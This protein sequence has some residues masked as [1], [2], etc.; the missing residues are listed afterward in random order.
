MIYYFLRSYLIEKIICSLYNSGHVIIQIKFEHVIRSVFFL[1][2][3]ILSSNSKI[4]YFEKKYN[5]VTMVSQENIIL[6][7]FIIFDSF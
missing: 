7:I 5:D 6:Y 4:F 2:C 1:R 3:D